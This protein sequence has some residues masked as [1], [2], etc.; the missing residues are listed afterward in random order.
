MDDEM[1]GP[2]FAKMDAHLERQD[3][4]LAAL[5][6]TLSRQNVMLVETAQM[7]AATRREVEARGAEASRLFAETMRKLEALIAR[8]EGRAEEGQG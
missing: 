8:L 6:E 5:T 4:Y 7:L 3:V 1:V 2:L